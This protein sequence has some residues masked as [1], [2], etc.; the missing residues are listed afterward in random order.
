MAGMVISATKKAGQGLCRVVVT[1][2]MVNA[3]EFWQAE[4]EKTLCQVHAVEKVFYIADG[5]SL[6]MQELASKI[7]KGE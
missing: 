6:A 7:I 5:I 2:G 3:R 1:G 4:F